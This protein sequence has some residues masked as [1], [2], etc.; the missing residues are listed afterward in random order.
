MTEVIDRYLNQ[1]NSCLKTLSSSRGREAAD[2]CRDLRLYCIENINETQLAYC[3][4][5][6]FNQDD[7]LITF[8]KAV[9][10]LDEFAKCKEV[11]LS[12]LAEYIAKVKT[13]ISPYATDIKDICLKLFTKDKN[14]RVKNETFEV[15]LQ[16]FELKFEPT[17]VEKLDVKNIVEK[18][19]SACSQSTKKKSSVSYGIYSLLG[20]LA[21]YFPEYMVDKADRLVQI[22]V[23]VLKAEMRKS[24]KPDMPVVAGCIRGLDSTL[25]NFTQS[26]NEGSIYA[27]N[28]YSF[29]RSAIDSKI[30]YARYDVP[31]AG[32]NFL[33]RHASQ[34]KEYLTK[35]YESV[36]NTLFDWCKRKN[37][38][39][40]VKGFAALEAFLKQ[41][42]ECLVTEDFETTVEC[43][44]IF[45]YFIKEFRRIIN[46]NES[47][48]REISIAIRGYGYFAKPCKV[49]LKDEDIKY[50]FT[51]II[52]MSEQMYFNDSELKE[53]KLQ[54]LPSFLEALGFIVEEIDEIPPAFLSFLERLVVVL[55]EKFPELGRGPQFIC[56]KAMLKLFLALTTRGASLKSFLSEI[57]YQGLIRTCSHP[58]LLDEGVDAMEG[59]TEFDVRHI[60]YKDYLELWECFLDGGQYKDQSIMPKVSSLTQD[61]HRAI[62]DELI[63][64]ILKVAHKLNL[65]SFR[66]V[67][68]QDED[69]QTEQPS[70]PDAPLLTTS[71]GT[72]DPIS[73][74]Q[75]EAPKDFQI[76]INLVEFSRK[77]LLK[78][79]TKWF[80]NWIY[81]FGK[82]L[83]VLSARFPLVSGFYKLLDI[84]MKISRKLDYFKGMTLK[85]VSTG[86][87]DDMETDQLDFSDCR[88]C[89]ILF[90]KFAMEVV[91]RMKQY[92]D[93]LKSSCL[94]LVLSLPNEL[95]L[96]DIDIIIPTLKT[97]FKLGLGF[98]PLAEAALD[99]LDTWT[100]ELPSEILHPYLREVLPQLD[101]YLKTASEL[102][103]SNEKE[104][105]LRSRKSGK[106][107][108][109]KSSKR[110]PNEEENSP[111]NKVRHRIL[112]LLGTLGGK[113]N[114]GLLEGGEGSVASSGIAWDTKQHLSFAVPFQDMKPTIFLDPFLPRVVELATSSS[115]R[116][117]K[118][119]ASEVFHSLVLFMLGKSV[120]IPDASSK[121]PLEK[122]WKRVFPVVLQLACD[123]EQVS[124]QLFRPLLFQLI[125][126]F[127][128][129]KQYESPD[130]IIL[131][132]TL[133]DGIVHPTDTALR[134]L[135]ALA[136][137]EFL[138]WSIKQATKNQ[139]E[140]SPINIKSL[141]KR[142]YS[143]ATHP[144][145]NKRLGAALAF[146]NIYRVFREES[147]LVENFTI[148]IL[149]TYLE[150]L[151]MAHEDEI[152]LGTQSQCIEVISHL[153]RIIVSKSSVLLNVNKKR[154][155]PRGFSADTTTLRH[156]IPWLVR[157]CGCSQ[158]ECRHQCM[159]LVSVLAPLLP[160]C[161]SVQTWMK[162]TVESDGED[163]FILR[164]ECGFAGKSGIQ[165][166][167][168]LSSINET[169]SLTTTKHWFDL[170]LAAL[171]SYIWSFG[172][173]L[174]TPSSI[175]QGKTTSVLW[176]TLLY[177]IEKLSL[178]GI[179]KAF[180]CFPTTSD[181]V[182]THAF[183]PSEIQEYNRAK[184]TVLVR[185]IAFITL[186]LQMNA[187]E[188]L[189][190]VPS[191]LWTGKFFEALC[192]SVLEPQSLGF[193]VADLEVLEKLP[194][195]TFELCKSL[196]SKLPK[197]FLIH[198]TTTLMS[199]ISL[200]GRCNLFELLPLPLSGEE[201]DQMDHT[202]LQLLVRGYQ[203]LH[204]AEILLPAL[205]K[206]GEWSAEK[207]SEELLK[208]VFQGF[209]VQ[210]SDVFR[211]VN[212]TP[213]S[214]ELAKKLL[215]L[216]FDLGLKIESVL[217]CILNKSCLADAKGSSSTVGMVFYQT[218]HN[219]IEHLLIKNSSEHLPKILEYNRDE[220]QWVSST[221]IALL[222]SMVKD[223]ELR[224]MNGR[225][226]TTVLL[227]SWERLSHWWE[228]GGEEL[229]RSTAIL[230]RNILIVDPKCLSEVKSSR[231]MF[232]TYNGL[233]KDK[234]ITLTVKIQCLELLPC[235]TSAT[236]PSEQTEALRSALKTLIAD[237]F[238]LSSKEFNENNPKYSDYIAALDKILSALVISGSLMLFDLLISIVCREESH[239]HEE[240]IQIQFAKF[241]KRLKL[242]Q[243]RKA[244]D[245]CF[246]VFTKK[247]TEYRNLTRRAAIDKVC[248]VLLR[249]SSTSVFREFYVDH[250][251]NIMEI[252]ETRFSKATDSV[253]ESQLVSKLCCFKLLALLYARLEKTDVSSME[254]RINRAYNN[255][256]KTGKELTMAITK[257]AHAAKSENM[258]GE[259]VLLP[260]RREYHCSAYNALISVISRTQTLLKFY[261]GFLF[262]EDL[263]KGQF[264]LDNLVDCTKKL[265]FEMELSAPLDKRTL[266]TSIR[267]EARATRMNS[268][269][270]YE[271]GVSLRYLSS[272]YLADSSLCEEVSQFDFSTPIQALSQSES[273]EQDIAGG[274]NSGTPASPKESDSDISSEELEMDELNRHDCMT[275]LVG[276]INHLVKNKI[277]PQPEQGKEANEMPPWM[278]Y[279]HKK[280]SH[281]SSE[282]NVRLFIAKLITNLPEVFEPYA[283][284]WLDSLM[285][286][287]LLPTFKNSELNYFVI[288]IV[289]TMLSWS[290]VTIPE[291]SYSSRRLTSRLLEYLMETCNHPTRSIFKNNLEVIKTFVEVWKERIDVPYKLIYERFSNA[292]VNTKENSVGIQLMGVIVANKITPF[293]P[294]CGVDEKRFYQDLVKNLSFKY[295]DVH[296][297]A[298]E[299]IG[300]ILKYLSE[301]N[302]KE[303]CDGLSGLLNEKLSS[304]T[305]DLDKFILCVHQLQIH[306][307]P[308]VDGFINQIL[309]VFQHV[310][311]QFK[312]LCLEII[313]S[314]VGVI[315]NLFLEL[316]TKGFLNTLTHRDEATQVACL[317]IILGRLSQMSVGD[318]QT[319]LPS[320]TDFLSSKSVACRGLMFD[321]LI[322]IYDT[323][324]FDETFKNEDSEGSEDVL[325]R[326]KNVLLQGLADENKEM[327]LKLRNFWS[328]ET[329]LPNSTLERLVQ[330]LRAMYSPITES[331][332][333]S[334]TTNLLLHLTSQSPDFGRLIFEQP[335]S[336]CK[337]QDYEI[338]FAWQQRNSTMT[339][340]FVS[341]LMP[342][343][344]SQSS[345]GSHSMDITDGGQLR[346]T[347]N[348][349]FSMTQ[350][351]G[352]TG[353]T[354]Q[355]YDWLNPSSLDTSQSSSASF[356]VGSQP[357]SLLFKSNPNMRRFKTLRPQ[358]EQPSTSSAAQ[359]D[360]PSNENSSQLQNIRKLK[361]R[362]VKDRKET[363]V[364]FA[365]KEIARQK[366]RTE[367]VQ[368]QKVA[369][370]NKVVM[371]R[372]Y[373]EGDLPDI[374]IKHS[375]LITPLQALAQCD[376]Y[377]AKQLFS[378][379]F[380]GIFSQIDEN[381]TDT[382]ADEI[383]RDIQDALNNM[384]TSSTQYFPPFI[385]CIQ[386]VCYNEGKLS[387]EAGKVTTASIG[388]L[389]QPTGIM[390]LEKQILQMAEDPGERPRKRQKTGGNPSPESTATWIELS[391]LYKS[392][393]DF[394][395]LQ[396][397]FNSH[398]GTQSI[399]KDA[400]EAEGRGDYTEA[401]KLYSQAT[402]C[403]EWPAGS[404]PL[405]AE[406]D[407][408][409]DSIL[410]CCRRL[411]L[412]DKMDH[413][414]I[415]NF[416][417]ANGVLDLNQ[418]WRD[419][420]YKEHYLP[421][422]LCS[423]TKKFCIGDRDEVFFNFIFD[424]L[425][426]EERKVYLENKYSDILALLFIL[427]EDYDRA[428]YY[429]SICLQAFLEDWSGLD[430]IMTSSRSAHLQSLQALTEMQEFLDFI[431]HEDN[432][433]TISSVK[434]LL[435][436]WSSR[437]PDPKLHSVGVWED[438][439][440]NRSVF[441]DK[442]LL[443]FGQSSQL[444]SSEDS[445]EIDGLNT[446]QLE[447]IF[448]RER[449]LFSLR[450]SE[451]ATGQVNFPVAKKQLQ[452]SL[453]LIRDRL[454]NDSELE[455][456]WTHSYGDLNCKKCPNLLP[457]EAVDTAIS[458]LDQLDKIKDSKVLQENAST[459]IRHHLLK[460]RNLDAITNVLS[461]PGTWDSLE[462]EAKEKLHGLCSSKNPEQLDKILGHLTT[463]SFT[464][465]QRAIKIAQTNENNQKNAESVRNLVTSSMTMAN[466]CDRLL[467]MKEEDSEQTP[468]LDMKLFPGIVIRFVLKSMA[469]ESAEA[470]QKFP[471][472]LQLVE[473]YPGGDIEAFKRKSSDVPCW[474][475][476]GWISQMVALLDKRE[477]HAVQGILQDLA[478]HYPQALLYPLKISAEQFKF[479]GS[480][481]EQK[482]KKFVESLN[483]SLSFPASDD[484]IQALE[485][486]TNP[487]MVFKDW[488][489]EVKVLLSTKGN[490]VKIRE[491]YGE[492]SKKLLN[493]KKRGT[494]SD[495][496]EFGSIR[497]KFAQEFSG[498]V[499]K[500]CG[501]D[502]SKIIDMSIKAFESAMKTTN[503]KM[504][505]KKFVGN[506]K[507]YSPWLA[508]FQT[509]SETIQ[510]EIPGQ[511]SGQSKP[512]PEYHV[513]VA[514]FGEKVKAMSSL[515]APKRITI[516]GNDEREHTFLVKGGE[517]LRLDQRIQQLFGLM[518]DVMRDD[519]ACHQRNLSLKT[520]KVIP[521][522][523]RIGVIEW[524]ENTTVLK[525]F[526]RNG[527][528]ETENETFD[529]I[530]YKHNKWIVEKFPVN[531]NKHII[532]NY[533]PMFKKASREVIERKFRELQNLMPHDA[534][535]RSFMRLASSPEAF[536]TL[537]AYFARTYGCMTICHYILGI[538]D[539]HLSNSMVDLKQGRVIGID[540]GHA[541][542]SATQFLPLPELMPFRLTRQICNMM[543]PL[544]VS[545]Q[546]QSTMV[547]TMRALRNNHEILLNT[548]DVFV[549]EPSLD[550]QNF[551][552]KQAEKQKLNLNDMTDLAWY[553]KEK[554]NSAKR[555]LKGENPA[556]IMKQ[557]LESGHKK[558]GYYEE[559]LSV[560][561]GDKQHN[562]RARH[563]VNTVENQVACLIDQATDPNILGR[564]YHGWEPWV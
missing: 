529:T 195:Q 521:M 45:K 169:F 81:T 202:R 104:T 449:V 491:S 12:F 94:Q 506:L 273:T 31:R 93:D 166:H 120:Q 507:D 536:L 67:E 359:S 270:N 42:A 475:F 209:I 490:A 443:K 251:K 271:H 470:R 111:L 207:C 172:Q 5:L 293:K 141:F 236:I 307:P 319:L 342:S 533:Y 173:R 1:L 363:D 561:L 502:G 103:T 39:L 126:W 346:A 340:L 215:D 109:S 145:A 34:Y 203:Q 405:Q 355:T 464:T 334:Y 176:R 428:R 433:S 232:K 347:Q 164:F 292:S 483:E 181:G 133:L 318:I 240:E 510:L 329:R 243:A 64:A 3:S 46:S 55:I 56:L 356:S 408:W 226:M 92:K 105:K 485:Q 518:N 33:A 522:T 526:I 285:E 77:I 68:T 143:L 501:E 399:T 57:V 511:Y 122:L 179:E 482:N 167:P 559:M 205:A 327:R 200:G 524:L 378:G 187:K 303:S 438:V 376:S 17:I 391:K 204:R 423:K 239:S 97:A 158:T 300:M 411:T 90:H 381:V 213:A 545:G 26:V 325:C 379:I 272:Q 366:L 343:G 130:T 552:R 175:F 312:T 208:S 489:D 227:E 430:S 278:S 231:G 24:G 100:A 540:F 51:S 49:F 288:D 246:D 525:E 214:R 456:L 384:I 439:M 259:T 160:E 394:D 268:S 157:K 383:F 517:D 313:L 91:V 260:L 244:L 432:F 305:K 454:K 152:S 365:K 206:E 352:A 309:F 116:Q 87:V 410:E 9:V 261:N 69:L 308:I 196:A 418:I 124:Q 74:I 397:I 199:K 80:E 539:R 513:K 125:H 193:N 21:E 212:L 447:E 138:R 146:N 289:V 274:E 469:F 19:F 245:I 512:L 431:S 402:N 37:K 254:S 385:S 230:I 237:N 344:S 252:I 528:S 339:P 484:L 458:A 38:E 527:L 96:C 216:A 30:N 73:G 354:A 191:E 180:E 54:N 210:D 53:E 218:F 514:G 296:G 234:T 369:R 106:T 323:Y 76:F 263:S 370:E 128:N 357:S 162:K 542:G 328:D 156:L 290:S 341:T 11:I 538:G 286:L 154:R 161:S 473:L 110:N 144:S 421:F 189:E 451:V 461:I 371:Y 41:V 437:E 131:L 118:V 297:A 219:T 95:V 434:S 471:R 178:N 547:Y 84:V 280:L 182:N 468:R 448:L 386:N 257:A 335:L 562:Q 185:I 311:A 250:I 149:V 486:L 349:Q 563:Y 264:L 425:K 60:S 108:A 123:V 505:A 348:P 426:N 148:E 494:N 25:V 531:G 284:F 267:C 221:V 427:D 509:Q 534:L 301:E 217:H 498:N 279:L 435:K 224:K 247:D 23:G 220:A 192:T 321:I 277:S 416:D 382:Q 89:F 281:H 373:R 549:K 400:L 362:F 298:A 222:D 137:E 541:F 315:P 338:N 453:H 377:I 496:L 395:V 40:R 474:M 310:H 287:I 295:K 168:T 406:E 140:K 78:T 99:A 228:N 201:C 336:E 10:Q 463:K 543:E 134:D 409:D 446:T 466:F 557:D 317:R 117:T 304:M 20:T 27:K 233:L 85:D 532:N 380:R 390:L 112:I 493:V 503:E 66:D 412:W 358:S 256:V 266:L 564:T 83:V 47:L 414:C 500:V 22:Y 16:L 459:G 519:A 276:L 488:M 113:C 467:R 253:F 322:W 101:G 98:L 282:L 504:K 194:E 374:Q 28:I 235:F 283:K 330:V 102:E 6:L 415:V 36:Y 497:R 44:D 535:R 35:D 225:K 326:T 306:F 350:T 75:P 153:E 115:D 65:S 523:S 548:M 86:C 455:V 63:Q 479:G 135:S 530:G 360:D 151:E 499:V 197:Q 388:S 275:T 171:D 50:M 229:K 136:L 367:S 72:T 186:L 558:A 129:N 444:H 351:A 337:F 508:N 170:V 71:G 7:G 375:D 544:R 420:Y 258:Q 345:F 79:K 481:E 62:Y 452:S 396:G 462:K 401:L 515:R 184:C 332:Y 404:S 537:R 413:N 61:I 480:I 331:E 392:V 29:L 132:E 387:L 361:R 52:Q 165:K 32:L 262:S 333:L 460:S 255:D 59:V 190:I 241:I 177:F 174:L 248:L 291:D 223:K 417:E 147:S 476:I 556:E 368:R 188:Y 294:G 554:I 450:L 2:I 520:Y 441:L 127:T 320:V 492:M 114:L 265:H 403:D 14:A 372:K 516:L 316:K 163:Y 121:S 478:K 389:Q 150:S 457:S 442:I 551:A 82:E 211:I 487:E 119:A 324:R 142:L 198:L 8:V 353:P 440:T 70:S 546:L 424:S 15:L 107:K 472:L 445:M 419:D 550:W 407:F 398:I 555:K 4:S 269:E 242:Q 429:T 183:S 302:D 393:E 553:P 314:R 477:S 495:G 159:R 560:L 436:R 48:T 155:V 139:L 13:R 465:L 364:Y 88:N 422:L 58:V 299:V 43:G 238:P 18:Y 249:A